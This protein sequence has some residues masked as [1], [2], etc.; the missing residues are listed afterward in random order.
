MNNDFVIR[1]IFMI[2][3]SLYQDY[4]SDNSKKYIF[5]NIVKKTPSVVLSLTLYKPWSVLWLISLSMLPYILG[6]P[7][8][9]CFRLYYF[10]FKFLKFHIIKTLWE[11]CQTIILPLKSYL[12]LIHRQ[13]NLKK[14]CCN[15]VVFKTFPKTANKFNCFWMWETQIDIYFNSLLFNFAS[16]LYFWS[17]V[18]YF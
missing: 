1:E 14:L 5:F 9:L 10:I 15:H 7:L 8:L 18:F 3:I 4:T 17:I 12:F 2:V 11:I 16:H 6:N 13:Q